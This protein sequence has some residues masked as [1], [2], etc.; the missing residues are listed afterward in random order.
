MTKNKIVLLWGFAAGLAACSTDT[1]APTVVAEAP[2]EVA[3]ETENTVDGPIIAKVETGQVFEQ[4]A[5]L[6]DLADPGE[7]QGK[8][9]AQVQTIM[10]EP[11]LVRRD[12][13]MQV[14]LFETNQCVLDVVF[15]ESS[16][17]EHF[18]ASAISARSRDGKDVDAVQC[19]ETMSN[20]AAGR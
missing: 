13:S 15:Y 5:P 18:R 16:V 14:M 4:A 9:P 12:G 19:L 11:D 3:K 17:G 20:R 6:M 1:P 10:G 8:T 2:P 7:L